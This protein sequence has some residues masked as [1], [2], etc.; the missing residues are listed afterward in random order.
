[1]IGQEG[2]ADHHICTL[3]RLPYAFPLLDIALD[4]LQVFIIKAQFTR[5]AGIGCDLMSSLQR[6]FHNMLT[7]SAWSTKCRYVH[8]GFPRLVIAST[9]VHNL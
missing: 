1:M 9:H 2:G 7:G 4:E 6:L 8:G 5:K 3:N